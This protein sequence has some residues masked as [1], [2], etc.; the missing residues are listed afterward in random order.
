LIVLLPAK[1]EAPSKTT[2]CNEEPGLVP[3]FLWA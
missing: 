2:S 3:G 1:L